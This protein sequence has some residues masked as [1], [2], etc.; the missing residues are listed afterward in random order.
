MDTNADVVFNTPPSD[1]INHLPRSPVIYC[2][3]NRLNGRRLVGQSRNGYARGLLYRSQMKRGTVTNFRLRRDV[4]QYGYGAFFMFVLDHCD[5][6]LKSHKMDSL[7]VWWTVQLQS[8]IEASGYNSEAGH[9]RTRASRFRD[10]ERKL[11]KSP[12][13]SKYC[14]L[15]D[16]DLYDPVDPDLLWSWLPGS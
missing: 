13:G 2:L 5:P 15:P 4:A 1:G 3:L 14:L 12:A 7:E 8:H 11:I 16:V 9:V 10:R 6:G